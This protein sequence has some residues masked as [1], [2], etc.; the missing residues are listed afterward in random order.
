MYR[1]CPARND[2]ARAYR[3]RIVTEGVIE[4]LR[5]F[6]VGCDVYDPV[7]WQAPGRSIPNIALHGDLRGSI[8]L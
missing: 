6:L 2:C 8:P 3:R 4:S 5:V 1:F 7:L